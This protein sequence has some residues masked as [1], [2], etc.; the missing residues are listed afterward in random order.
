M[1]YKAL[2][3]CPDERTAKTVTQVL[4]EL[5][6]QVEACNE[7]FAAVKMLMAG[8]FDAV[9][10]DCD[11]E[12]NATLLFKSARNS[13]FNQASLSVAVVEGQ[14]G[15]AKAFRIGANLVLTKPINVEQS[16][17]TLRVARGLL[18]KNEAAKT[19]GKVTETPVRP[20]ATSPSIAPPSFATSAIVPPARTIS[21][22]PAI[23]K[24][25]FVTNP[26]PSYAPAASSS[27]AFELEKDPTPKPEPAEA[28]FLESVSDQADTIRP[29]DQAAPAKKQYPWQAASKPVAESMAGTMTTALKHAAEATGKPDSGISAGYGAAAAPAKAKEPVAIDDEISALDEPTASIPVAVTSHPSGSAVNWGRIAAIILIAA[30]GGAIYRAGTQ[31]HWQVVSA[32]SSLLHKTSAAATPQ[33]SKPAANAPVS[34]TP[35]PIATTGMQL[36]SGSPS[37]RPISTQNST[38]VAPTPQKPSPATETIVIAPSPKKST[39]NATSFDPPTPPG[40]VKEIGEGTVFVDTKTPRPTASKPAPVETVDATAP[41]AVT[42]SSQSNDSAISGLVS[43]PSS[44]PQPGPGTLKISQGVSQGLLIKKV[45]PVYPARAMHAHLQG[46]VLLLATISKDGDITAVKLL[47]GEP[48]LA[49]AAMDAVKQWKYKPYLLDS[50]P[51]EIQTQITVNFT[52]P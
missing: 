47:K 35:A 5:E 32:M 23:S 39:V 18:R 4:S 22:P 20:Q 48:V 13:E 30:A 34:G 27:S 3:F 28:A 6:F 38:P 8:H 44:V 16:K 19:S 46:S 37:A 51:M 42:A 50:Q 33:I 49:H 9:V 26:A 29:H 1:S 2:L 17:G 11:N 52:L 25:A 43:M 41:D 10:V 36:Q 40:V 14:S 15:V 31:T 7:P 24:P 12:Q 21:V 45:A